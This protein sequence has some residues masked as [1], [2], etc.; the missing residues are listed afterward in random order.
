[1]S[2]FVLTRKA[3]DDLRGIGRYT[4]HAWGREQRSRYL[5]ILDQSFRD[6]AASPLMGHDCSTIRS[7][8]RKYQVE[9]HIIFYRIMMPDQIEIV[10]I[11]HERMDVTSA[12]KMTTNSS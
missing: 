4:E 10:R 8:Y 6:L 2:G 1:M 12:H 9:R 5:S 7:G 3:L 11:L